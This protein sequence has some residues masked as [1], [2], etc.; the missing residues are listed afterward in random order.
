MSSPPD[1]ILVIKNGT[2][3]DGT[4]G[5]PRP[6][7]LS[8]ATRVPSNGPSPFFD[9]D[10]DAGPDQF[11][12]SPTAALLRLQRVPADLCQRLVEQSRI[13]PGIVDDFGAGLQARIKARRERLALN[14]VA[15]RCDLPGPF[16]RVPIIAIR[17][18]CPAGTSMPRVCL[19]HTAASRRWHQFDRPIIVSPAWGIGRGAVKG[20]T[21]Q[22]SS[23]GSSGATSATSSA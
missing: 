18:A 11:A 12:L 23:T 14:P 5:K 7:G 17:V 3:V 1:S 21:S 2:L 15:G 13:V 8:M 9:K 10:R 16:E 22:H 20:G 4:G 6:N 19:N